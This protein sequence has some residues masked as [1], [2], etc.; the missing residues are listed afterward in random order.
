M[1]ESEKLDKQIAAVRASKSP[2]RKNSILDKE[3]LF[4]LREAAQTLLSLKLN[5]KT[6]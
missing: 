2:Y 5:L 4:Q 6:K 1:T 3:H